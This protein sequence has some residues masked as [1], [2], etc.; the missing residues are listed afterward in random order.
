MSL[1]EEAPSPLADNGKLLPIL[2]IPGLMSSGLEIKE[3]KINRGWEGKRIW[4]NLSSVGISAMYFGKAQKT[5]EDPS[6]DL[7]DEEEKDQQA[8]CKSS[9]LT[10]MLLNGDKESD[11]PGI[12]VR[13][14]PGLEGVDYMAPGAFTSTL[15][16]V[17]GPVIKILEERGYNSVDGKIN[18]M[19]A[20]YD[21]RGAIWHTA[22]Q[23]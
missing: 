3:S 13:A 10:H 14:V 19:A 7:D 15:S 12:K 6:Q 20:P 9:W 4:L 5:I 16:Y 18:L 22:S 8:K 23:V 11:A 1:E 2:I 21:W 17:F